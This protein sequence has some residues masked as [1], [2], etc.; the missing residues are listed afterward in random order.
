[1]VS[2]VWRTSSPDST[3]TSASTS[4]ARA[5]GVSLVGCLGIVR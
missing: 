4:K 5:Y 1:M 3:T 2:P